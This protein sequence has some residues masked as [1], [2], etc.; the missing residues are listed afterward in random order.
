MKG[1]FER[2]F[3]CLHPAN[4]RRALFRPGV[5][6][7]IIRQNDLVA[8]ELGQNSWVVGG[9]YSQRPFLLRWK[10]I[11]RNWIPT[12][13]LLKRGGVLLAKI[14]YPTSVKENA[15]YATCLAEEC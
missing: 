7:S 15:C 12:R 1:L 10:K 5:D 11:R 6:Q 14:E 9:L 8:R 4:N 2:N 13:N 3:I